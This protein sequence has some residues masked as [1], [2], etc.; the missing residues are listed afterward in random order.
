MRI[1]RVGAEAQ[2][3]KVDKA[4]FEGYK[5]KAQSKMEEM[6][7]LERAKME[8]MMKEMQRKNQE[9]A[10]TDEPAFRAEM[11]NYTLLLHSQPQD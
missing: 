9:A 11:K 8:E 6:Q 10:K 5:V 2:A 7:K 4:S 3:F 1:E